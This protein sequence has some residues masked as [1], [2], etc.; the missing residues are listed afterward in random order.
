MIAKNFNNLQNN[1]IKS[2]PKLQRR[3]SGNRRIEA[4]TR[5]LQVALR[6]RNQNIIIKNKVSEIQRKLAVF[7]CKN[8]RVVLIEKLSVSKCLNK[9]DKKRNI[10]R[11]TA[12]SL[13]MW[14]HYN[15]RQLL[16]DKAELVYSWCQVIEVT[17]EFTSQTCGRCGN[18]DSN[19]GGSKVYECKKCGF[20]LVDRDVNGARNILLNKYLSEYC[21]LLL[22]DASLGGFSCI[23]N[24]FFQSGP[25]PYSATPIVKK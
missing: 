6:R 9:K 10:G 24:A 18:V 1:V 2:N 15:F 16:K 23:F 7:L 14:S 4:S 3:R 13:Q 11:S 8:Y 17:E 20:T 25:Y 21:K 5:K 22:D 12:R 19:L